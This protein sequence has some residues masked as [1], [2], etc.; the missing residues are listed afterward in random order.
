MRAHARDGVDTTTTNSTEEN[1]RRCKSMKNKAV[2]KVMREK[3]EEVLTEL[4]K[5]DV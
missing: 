1:K 4:L 2:S 5:W 3:A